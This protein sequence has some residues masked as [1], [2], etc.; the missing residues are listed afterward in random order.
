MY[1]VLSKDVWCLWQ[2]MSLR[3]AELALLSR[4]ESLIF[5]GLDQ[6][7]RARNSAHHEPGWWSTFDEITAI[8]LHNILH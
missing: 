3:C 6:Q 2:L 7:L 8:V 1:T 5:L 4:Q